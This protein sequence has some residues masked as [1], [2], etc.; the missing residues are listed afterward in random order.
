[1]RMPTTIAIT[2]TATDCFKTDSLEG[3]T[4]FLNSIPT[5]LKNPGLLSLVL[6]SAMINSFRLGQLL[7][8]FVHGVTLAES[9]VFLGL[10][11]IGMSLF[12][13]S[14]IVI[15]LFALCA[16]Q[17]DLCTHILSLRVS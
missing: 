3:H 15:T 8:L 6:V 14:G 7:G 9:A 1:M 4:I 2:V 13:L 10:H 12:I 11:T 16:C 5:V 17:C